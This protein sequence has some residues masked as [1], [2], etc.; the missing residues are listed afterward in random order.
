MSSQFVTVARYQYSAEALIVKGKLESEGIEVFMTDMHTIDIDPLASNAIGGVKVKVRSRDRFAASRVLESIHPYSV[1]NNQKP[2]E[3]PK[4]NSK[5]VI[6]TTTIDSFKGLVQ[7]LF[8]FLL[9][10][11]PTYQKFAYRCEVCE[12]QFNLK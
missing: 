6:Y 11:L 3:C 9:F 8:G 7:Y 2:I 12:T 1:D 4:C 10:L 5:K